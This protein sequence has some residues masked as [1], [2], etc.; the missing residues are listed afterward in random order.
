M[1][2]REECGFN[3]FDWSW[4]CV[5]RAVFRDLKFKHE[6]DKDMFCYLPLH[7]DYVVSELWKC[8]DFV[9]WDPLHMG[10]ER[11]SEKV[12]EWRRRRRKWEN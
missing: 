6:T 12:L 10:K 4:V 2:E 9:V 1:L 7:W 11:E 3:V 8:G 5:V